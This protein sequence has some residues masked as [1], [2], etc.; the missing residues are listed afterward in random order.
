MQ[1]KL[2][3]LSAFMAAASA[4]VEDASSLNPLTVLSVLQ[5]ALPSSLY[6]Q[7]LISPTAVASQVASQFAAGNTPSWYTALPTPIQSY[8]Q[9]S[10]SVNGTGA[11]TNGTA[12]VIHTT[13]SNSS[14]LTTTSTRR[15]GALTT[16]RTT[17]GGNDETTT[18]TRA[19]GA[20]SDASSSA[21]AGSASA[22]ES[23]GGASLPTAIV[24]AGVAGVFGVVGLLAL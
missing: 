14:T 16:E 8:L 11:V 4:Q 12:G 21:A 5:T 13:G 1:F 9:A 18:R 10:A 24:G 3:A 6:S 7:A 19:G 22:S 17:R 20:G 2:I 23:T 15:T